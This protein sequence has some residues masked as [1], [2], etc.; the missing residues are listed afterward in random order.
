MV[1]AG[2]SNSDVEGGK[3]TGL[4]DGTLRSSGSD[5]YRLYIT[6]VNIH[7][8]DRK[9]WLT[10]LHKGVRCRFRRFWQ[11]TEDA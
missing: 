5:N 8:D 1:P 6:L 3:L 7:T 4:A 10:I 9:K 11:H 2:G